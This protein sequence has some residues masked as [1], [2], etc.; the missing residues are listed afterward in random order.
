MPKR[1]ELARRQFEKVWLLPELVPAKW[2]WQARLVWVL[3]QGA[4]A[5][6]VWQ[7]LARGQFW[8]DVQE[9]E[10]VVQRVRARAALD[11]EK[12]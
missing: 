4:V 1:L 10:L 12:F 5:L 7:L 6:A 3:R 9:P 2:V 11:L 8:E